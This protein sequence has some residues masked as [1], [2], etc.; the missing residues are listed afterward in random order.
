MAARHEQPD[1]ILRRDYFRTVVRDAIGGAL[2]APGR[3]ERQAVQDLREACRVGMASSALGIYAVADL[4][5]EAERPQVG[6]WRKRRT[7][8]RDAEWLAGGL[9]ERL[10]IV[11]GRLWRRCVIVTKVTLGSRGQAHRTAE[12]GRG[13]ARKVVERLPVPAED[14]IAQPP[15]LVR[16][17]DATVV[18]IAAEPHE[19]RLDEV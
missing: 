7:A 5:T 6:A 11:S 19:H 17:K 10:L 2:L 13:K 12:A 1:Q 3:I 18:G 9:R 14:Q 4:Q 15:D 8:N 16:T